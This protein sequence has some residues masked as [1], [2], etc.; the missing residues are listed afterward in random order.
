MRDLQ[1]KVAVITGGASGI[2]RAMAEAFRDSGMTVVIAD[3][4]AVAHERTASELGVHHLHVDVT[5]EE[6]VAAGGVEPHREHGGAQGGVPP[7]LSTTVGNP[8]VEQGHLGCE[9]GCV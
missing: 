7:R 3:V 5:K 1:G 8:G 9:N 6:Q 2:G 4:E